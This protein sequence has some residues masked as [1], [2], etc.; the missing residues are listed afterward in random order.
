MSQYSMKGPRWESVRKAAKN[1]AGGMCENLCGRDGNEADHVI[2]LAMGGEPYELSNIRWLCKVC[3]T[4][5]GSRIMEQERL[6]W[7]HPL[8]F[9][10]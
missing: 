9:T 8:W 3:N 4:R 2:P 10:N 5:K 6:T 1:R 7:K